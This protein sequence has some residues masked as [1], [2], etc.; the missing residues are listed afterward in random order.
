MIPKRG[1][2][3]GMTTLI[4]L[5]G[6]TEQKTDDLS[7]AIRQ[8]PDQKA[9]QAVETR[10]DSFLV[11]SP[12][13]DGGTW[14]G[15]LAARSLEI[16]RTIDAERLLYRAVREYPDSKETPENLLALANIYANYTRQVYAGEAIC[17]T[18]RNRTDGDLSKK[19]SQCCTS[20]IVI[21]VDSTLL[22]LRDSVFNPESAKIDLRMAK[23]YIT[24]G[25][26]RALLY[27]DSDASADHLN[28]AAKVAKAIKDPRKAIYLYDWILEDYRHTPY[29][30][31]AMF[32]KAFT[33]ENDLGDLDAAKETYS[34]YIKEWPKDD[35]ADDARFLLANLG[36]DPEQI[37]EEI[38]KS[39][40]VQ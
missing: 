26:V 24:L 7:K 1:I 9:I 3:V 13:E 10:I 20:T 6:C 39:A 8:A 15:K 37:M 31:K 11:A 14:Y 4:L 29:G 17:C 40:P 27:A 33:Y 12:S 25:Q 2:L 28:E 35:F 19:A 21:P 34:A 36:K 18:V 5:C 22:M 38:I 30:P 32:L 16:S 23:N